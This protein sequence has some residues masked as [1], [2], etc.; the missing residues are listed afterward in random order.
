MLAAALLLPIAVA[1]ALCATGLLP[2]ARR[3][4]VRRA[5]TI[6]AP[7]TALPA[8]VLA[9]LGPG[10]SAEVPWLLLGTSLHVDAV[11]RP[12]VLVT[13]LLHGAAL[14]AIAWRRRADTTVGT[15]VL[16]AFLLACLVGSLG[17]LLAAD[18]VTFY[19]S[20]VLVSF[21]AAGLV[22]HQRTATA[23]RATR[24]YLV[25]SV[26]SET[27][28]LAALLLVVAAGGRRIADAP[29]A[30]ADAGTGG[31]VVVLLLVGFGVKA[32]TV[33]LH[34]W[35]PLAHPAAPPAAS[36]V[37][38]GVLVKIG[39][40][41]WVRFL[42]LGE[43]GDAVTVAGWTLLVLSLLGAFLAVAAGLLQREPKVV[44]AYSTISQLGFLGSVVAVGLLE[45]ALAGATVA[46]AVLYAVHHGLAKGAL[47]LGVPVAQGHVRGA[48]GVV[49][50]AGT[51]VAALV[52][53]GAPLTSGALGKYVSKEAVGDVAILGVAVADLLP[54]V[55][56]GSTLLLLRFAWVLWAGER[57]GGRRADGELAA[58][59]L[60]VLAAVALPWWVAARWSPLALPTWDAGTLWDAAWPILLGL[61]LAGPVVALRR[62]GRLPRWAASTGGAGLPPGD[63]VVL[64]EAGWAGLRSGG[65]RGLAR[66]HRGTQGA[67]TRWSDGWGRLS[68]RGR[69]VTSAVEARLGAWESSGTAV[70]LLLGVV[71]TATGV[72][73]VTGGWS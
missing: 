12:L 3:P 65:S 56:T 35:L 17:A 61:A 60:L 51:L 63:L 68:A 32:G 14:A 19:L 64:E 46:A 49:V 20:F 27:A 39:L 48:D 45:P 18:T 73:L 53:A 16:T 33:P 47:F 62:A 58:W 30:V 38:S 66:L 9:V 37:L 31:L 36:A 44:L 52:V 69:A 23:H 22:V 21:A 25:M 4:G 7:A 26:L 1:L 40:I 57:P 59:S 13:A 11:A 2:P 41:G 10:V 29:A 55:A 54:L 67:A 5:L 70:L 24:V 50:A 43:Q 34:V 42:P 71:V 72:A 8:L 6:L 28:I 15:G